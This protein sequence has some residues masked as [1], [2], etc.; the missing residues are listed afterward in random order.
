MNKT[1]EYMAETGIKKLDIMKVIKELRVCNYSYT[2][3][4]RNENFAGDQIWI[5]GTKFRP[6]DETHD[7]YIKLKIQEL[8]EEYLRI[9]SF[10][11]ESP[12]QTEGK[13]TFPYKDYDED[14]AN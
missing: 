7:I 3:L 10:H 14:N 8:G 2:T 13:L 6:V 11:P 5:F 4:D 1:R 12:T 9:L